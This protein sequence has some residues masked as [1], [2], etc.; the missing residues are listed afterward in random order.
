MLITALWR[1]DNL[2]LSPAPPQHPKPI[3]GLLC[4]PSVTVPLPSKVIQTLSQ[5]GT[6]DLVVGFI[7]AT[8]PPLTDPADVDTYFTS[9]LSLNVVS[10]FEFYRTTP[11]EGGTKKE[12]FKKLIET[13]VETGGEMA[14]EVVDLPFDEEERGWFEEVLGKGGDER[15]REM[16]SVWWLHVG[17]FEDAVGVMGKMEEVGEGGVS[18]GVVEEG[19]RKGLGGRLEIEA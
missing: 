5:H 2:I 9:L 15:R 12:L 19:V 8:Q 16:L 11:E 14:E 13:A 4:N 17:K 1:L 3:L 6:P 18:W 10:A 7:S